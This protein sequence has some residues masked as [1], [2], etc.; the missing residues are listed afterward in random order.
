[1]CDDI[2]RMVE[3]AQKSV[4]LAFRLDMELQEFGLSFW[5]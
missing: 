3:R 1:V 2:K 5:K 4:E